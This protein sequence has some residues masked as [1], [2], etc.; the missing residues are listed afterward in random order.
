MKQGTAKAMIHA[1]DRAQQTP[2]EVRAAFLQK[3]V[4]AGGLELH[5]LTL[6]IIW[7]LEEIQSPLIEGI[8]DGQPLTIRQQAEAAFVFARPDEAR[9]ALTEGR[10]AFRLE[11]H[12][13]AAQIVPGDLNE[14]AVAIGAILNEGLA[15]IPGA[16]G[17]DQ[18]KTG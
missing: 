9:A 11:A 2:D 13:L 18:K 15:T 6:G 10:D 4:S 17:G 8:K 5:P 1:R 16:T 3:R 7:L 12:Q 14:I